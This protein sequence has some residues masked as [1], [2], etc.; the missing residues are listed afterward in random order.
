[1]QTVFELDLHPDPELLDVEGRCG[2]IDPELLA[3]RA[4][5]V[6]CEALVGLRHVTPPSLRYEASARRSI[7]APLVQH[8]ELRA[9]AKMKRYHARPQR[10]RS[11]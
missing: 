8:G 7:P 2:P 9:R 4:S 10:S 6:R 11:S 1:V 3:D 5:L